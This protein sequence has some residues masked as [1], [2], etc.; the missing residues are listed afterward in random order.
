MQFCMCLQSNSHLSAL[1]LPTPEIAQ[2][3]E[4]CSQ[5]KLYITPAYSLAV[6]TDQVF[7][8]CGWDYKGQIT[9]WLP[10]PPIQMILELD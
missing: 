10:F 5:Q 6:P 7:S 9:C 2:P 8:A 3:Q 4:A 1:L